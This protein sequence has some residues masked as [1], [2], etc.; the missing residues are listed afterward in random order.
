[1]SLRPST[2]ESKMRTGKSVSKSVVNLHD[3]KKSSE[4]FPTIRNTVGVDRGQ[5]SNSRDF[6]AKGKLHL[7]N[8]SKPQMILSK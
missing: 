2:S 6:K 5:R 8:L 1:M 7:G 4:N 3:L